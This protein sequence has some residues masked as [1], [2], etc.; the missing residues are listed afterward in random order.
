MVMKF[1]FGNNYRV[2]AWLSIF[3]LMQFLLVGNIFGFLVK[4][5]TESGFTRKSAIQIFI[6]ISVLR[7]LIQLILGLHNPSITLA[8]MIFGVIGTNQLRTREIEQSKK[9]IDEYRQS[10]PG[11]IKP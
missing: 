11:R 10:E 4:K 2:Y 1:G 7:L 5:H 9:R 3:R 8:F 6:L